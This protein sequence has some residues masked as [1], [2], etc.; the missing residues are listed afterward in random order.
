[1]I[2][3]AQIFTDFGPR[4]L[5]LHGSA[6]SQDQFNAFRDI[7]E[8]RTPR[9]GGNIFYCDACDEMHYSYHS[10]GNRH[11]PKCQNDSAEKWLQ[12]QYQR[13]LP[14]PYFMV[15][16]TLPHSIHPIARAN[17]NLIYNMLFQTAAQALQKLAADPRFVGGTLGMVGVLHT[18]QRNL[19]YHPHVHFIATGGGLSADQRRWKNASPKLLVHVKALSIIFRAK[20]RDECQRQNLQRLIDPQTWNKLW[21]VHC[22]PVGSGKAA[23]KYLAPYIFRVALSNN[24]IVRYDG[25]N[26]TLRYID[27]KTKKTA[28]RIMTAL[29]FIQQF[30]QHVLPKR[31]VKVRYYGLLA[32]ANKKLLEQARALLDAKAWKPES[33]QTKQQIICPKCQRPMH[34]LASFRYQGRGPPLSLKQPQSLQNIVVFRNNIA[35]V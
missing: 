29:V 28:A 12:A 14:T 31:F 27:S 2:E 35:C 16:F 3:T 33:I 15:T 7:V 20:F 5:E 13:L 30:L 32:A 22:E 10:C 25:E 34:W 8:C 23:F 26:V 1:M 9:L 24:R 18:W 21:V 17:P 4:Y 11:C 19:N 6:I